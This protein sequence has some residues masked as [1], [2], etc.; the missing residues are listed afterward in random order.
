MHPVPRGEAVDM[1]QGKVQSPSRGEAGRGASELP[2]PAE[3]MSIVPGEGGIPVEEQRDL[4]RIPI[5]GAMVTDSG[6]SVPILQCHAV[7]RQ[8]AVIVSV[9]VADRS[10]PSRSRPVN[11]IW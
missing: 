7:S 8:A 2:F 11:V 3:R 9:S 4:A 1:L 10:R 6:K 5:V